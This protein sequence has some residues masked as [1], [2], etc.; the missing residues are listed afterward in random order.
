M[1]VLY[2][3]VQHYFWI[4]KIFLNTQNPL[5]TQREIARNRKEMGDRYKINW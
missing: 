4:D 1:L 5:D 3:H 2:V